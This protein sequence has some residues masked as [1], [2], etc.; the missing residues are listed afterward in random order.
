MSD[1]V[2]S[3]DREAARLRDRLAEIEVEQAT[4][5]AELAAFNADYMRVVM[6]VMLDVQELEARILALVAARSGASDDADAAQSARRR[7]NETT[8]HIRAVPKSPGPVPTGDIKKLFR[9]AA[10]RMHP[11]LAGDEEARGHAEAF[12]KRLNASYRAGDAEGIVNLLGQWEASPFG[13]RS[14]DETAR[15][16]RAERRVGA[17]G[18]ADRRAEQRLEELR[19]SELAQ[20]LDRAMA[21]AAAGRDLLADMR[22]DAEAALVRARARLAELEG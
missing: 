6:T 8:A 14:D 3:A 19:S 9:E 13:A 12:M 5:E 7:V 11:D 21:T 17:L 10:K 18:D 4:L 20:L 15:S 1:L 2:T 22:R 16:A